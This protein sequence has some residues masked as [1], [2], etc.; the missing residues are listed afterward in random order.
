MSFPFLVIVI[1]SIFP[2]VVHLLESQIHIS[3]LFSKD[4]YPNLVFLPAFPSAILTSHH[5]LHYPVLSLNHSFAGFITFFCPLSPPITIQAL[6][7][8]FLNLGKKKG[9]VGAIPVSDLLW[10]LFC[11][12]ILY[13]LFK[14]TDCN[15]YLESISLAFTSCFHWTLL[16]TWPL[17]TSF[18]LML[19]IG[20]Y[21]LF[22]LQLW[23]DFILLF[24]AYHL[25]FF[26]KRFQSAH[27]D[28]L[29]L[30][31]ITDN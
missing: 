29:S 6:C 26:I 10:Q 30:T 20:S 31:I 16:S 2:R 23:C 28:R 15:H 18:Y 27:V 3:S 13:L 22:L 21:F 14:L 11:H 12:L 5:P 7:S 24:L 17:M 1:L 4:S 8:L 25:S 9:G 19:W